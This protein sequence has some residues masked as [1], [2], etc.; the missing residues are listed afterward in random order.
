VVGQ[1]KPDGA[2]V[3]VEIA[4]NPIAFDTL[5]YANRLKQA[6]FSP[7]QTEALAGALAEALDA[8]QV[9]LSTKVDTVSVS[10]AVMS[11]IA[12]FRSALSSDIAAFKSELSSEF[13]SLRADLAAM[14]ARQIAALEKMGQTLFIRLGSLMTV[15]IGFLAVISRMPH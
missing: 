4:L 5:K 3:L 13:A 11:D 12:A 10:S 8:H 7:E 2:A 9:E 6:G 1:P 15:Q 14:E